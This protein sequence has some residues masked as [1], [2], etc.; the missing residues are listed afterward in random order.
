[1]NFYDESLFLFKF[2]YFMKKINYNKDKYIDQL[3][4]F[5]E[6]SLKN[7]FIILE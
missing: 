6:L 2:D 4:Y 3:K 1:M 5:V 7:F